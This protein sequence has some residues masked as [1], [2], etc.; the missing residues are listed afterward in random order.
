MIQFFS[1]KSHTFTG[2]IAQDL[3]DV[4]IATGYH[5]PFL[6]DETDPERLAVGHGKLLPVVIKALQE[7]VENLENVKKENQIL[8]D[9]TSELEKRLTAIENKF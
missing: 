6:V 9:K 4:M 2:F 8:K 3:R 7:T 1:T 5:I